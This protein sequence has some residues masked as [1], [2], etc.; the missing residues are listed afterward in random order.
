MDMENPNNRITRRRPS[1]VA[2]VVPEAPQ[3]S[4]VAP[5]R[6]A[7]AK[8]MASGRAHFASVLNWW[9]ARCNYSHVQIGAMA[10]WALAQDG[11]LISSQ[12]SHL[13]NNH[14]RQPS[15]INLEALGAVNQVLHLWHTEGPREVFHRHGPF[16]DSILSEDLLER[17]DW[18]KHPKTDEPLD[19]AGFCELFVGR[20]K[21]QQAS[22]ID[23]LDH[24]AKRISEELG[25]LLDD[26]AATSGLSPREAIAKV[27]LHYP[28]HDRTRCERLKAVM[29]GTEVYTP[30]QVREEMFSL[31]ELVQNFRG[32]PAGTYG[33][34][35]LLSEL[36]KHRQRT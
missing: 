20:I 14:V 18:L 1:A 7:V 2:Q 5:R 17:G 9:M 31:S 26:L 16:G 8:R 15:F 32:L 23:F 3:V 25:T 11:W 24:D 28:C 35:E 13:R 29:L 33:P 12:I 27:L 30:Q 10:D 6:I 19:F 21:L 34:E 22:V 36:T 4:V